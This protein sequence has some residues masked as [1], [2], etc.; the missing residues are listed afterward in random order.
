[1]KQRISTFQSAIKKNAE[2]NVMAHHGLGSNPEKM[3]E[4]VASLFQYLKYIYP[5]TE[6]V[7]TNYFSISVKPL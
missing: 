5:C 4:K 3:Q 1:M 6:K 2:A 7:C